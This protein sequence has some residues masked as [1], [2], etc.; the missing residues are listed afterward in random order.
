MWDLACLAVLCPIVL[1]AC[2][3]AEDGVC[4]IPLVNKRFAAHALDIKETVSKF[5]NSH[6]T[7]SSRGK[8]T[9][10]FERRAMSMTPL[11][12][13]GSDGGTLFS[14]RGLVEVGTPQQGVALLFDTGSSALWMQSNASNPSLATSAALFDPLQSTTLQRSADSAVT[15]RY[16]D[17]TE[18]NGFDAVD[19]VSVGTFT[20]PDLS[21]EIA[22]GVVAPGDSRREDTDGIL[23]LSFGDSQ[24]QSFFE[25]LATSGMLA[26]P[27]FGYYIGSDSVSGGLTFGGVEEAR[28][29]GEL[30]FVPLAP[31][32]RSGIRSQ[33]YSAWQTMLSDVTVD[34]QPTIVI[35]NIVLFDTGTSLAVLPVS[36]AESINQSMGFQPITGVQPFRFALNCQNGKIPQGLPNITFTLSS[37]PLTVTP[38]EYVFLQHNDAGS[39]Y[40]M[41]GFVGQ[42]LNPTNDPLRPSTI[43]GN[44]LLRRFYTVF[45][46]GDRTIGFAVADRSSG[47]NATLSAA[48]FTTTL[49]SAASRHG[50]ATTTTAKTLVVSI[51][52]LAS[53]LVIAF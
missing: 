50:P 8:G 37:K 10:S 16:V 23:G 33:H 26:S 21:F 29:Q 36:L 25:R 34:G 39:V 30:A 13:T 1:G 11:Q 24:G 28:I 7:P 12:G 18:V 52:T 40:C 6:A 47:I 2:E 5:Q 15:I 43:F 9:P 27:S 44:V 49:A 17:G 20:I 38:A 51:L 32:G 14:Y 22:T 42:D 19:T 48:G 4:H 46:L 3:I 45:S 35:D 41:S 53:V 31:T